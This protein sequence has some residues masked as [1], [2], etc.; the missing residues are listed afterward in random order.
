M[1]L[2]LVIAIARGIS[3]AEQIELNDLQPI[4]QSQQLIPD[5]PLVRKIKSRWLDAECTLQRIQDQYDLET[6]NERWEAK[7]NE[8]QNYKEAYENLA[9][10]R[11]LKIRQLAS[12]TRKGQSRIDLEKGGEKGIDTLRLHLERELSGGAYCLRYI[13]QETEIYRQK[14]RTALIGAC[15]EM[16]QAEKDW[17]EV[18]RRNSFKPVLLALLIAFSIGIMMNPGDGWC[19]DASFYSSSVD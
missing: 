12:E 13:K 4:F 19:V 9:Q 2:F 10:M 6:G 1:S 3:D 18:I 11:D 15:R 8:L 16:A 17:H 5:D 14:L 7:R